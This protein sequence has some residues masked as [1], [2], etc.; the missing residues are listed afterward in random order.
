[1]AAG[2]LRDFEGGGEIESWNLVRGEVLPQPFDQP[3]PIELLA[4]TDRANVV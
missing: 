4:G 1:M 2:E 3:R